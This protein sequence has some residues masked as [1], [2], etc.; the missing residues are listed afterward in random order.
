MFGKNKVPWVVAGILIAAFVIGALVVGKKEKKVSPT[1]KPAP[2]SA[3][4]VVVP[5][6]LA[7]T[8]F[9]PPCNTP[10]E[11]T[12]RVAEQGETPPGATTV[13]LP[14]GDGTRYV[15]VPHCQPGSG[16]TS[17]P[18][19][20]PSSAIVLA[21]KLRPV[22]GT[23]GTFNAGGAVARTQ[24]ILPNGSKATTLVIPPCRKKT[25]GQR[26]VVLGEEKAGSKTVVAPGC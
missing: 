18:G 17:A 6:T 14:K 11:Q 5:G 23:G 10:V 9:V 19:N 24:L 7:R 20:I 26:D 4:A 22:E 2:E 3:R 16:A 1:S 8:V 13:K 21:D 15:M 12:T 25:S